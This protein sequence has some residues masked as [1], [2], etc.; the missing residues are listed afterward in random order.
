[1]TEPLKTPDVSIIVAAWRCG[2][3]IRPAI[4]SALAAR[5]VSIEVIVVDDA[6]PDDTFEVL[7][8][9]AAQDPRVRIDRLAA[10]SGPS[11]ARNRAIDLASGE[12]IAVLDA[13]DAMSP[14]RLRHMMECARTNGA[15]IV[16]DDL[17]AVDADGRRSEGRP[18]LKSSFFRQSRPIDLATWVRY[19]TPARGRDSIGYLKPLI[20]RALLNRMGVRY[21]PELR[22][23][24]DYDL[25]A[26]LLAC[27]ARMH[28]TAQAGYFYQR[29]PGSIS[30]RLTPKHT[31]DWIEADIRFNNRFGASLAPDA[32]RAL[33]SRRRGLNDAHLFIC[34]VEAIK[35]GRGRDLPGLFLKSPLSAPF[36]AGVLGRI[37]LGKVIGRRIV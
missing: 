5:D 24:E 11:G 17:I 3:K 7:R 21:D 6:S 15:D 28:F 2:D 9:I 37:A 1:M 13:D 4:H 35:Q 36:S 19:N 18:F 26:R 12:F 27:G 34:S 8:D 29:S 23:G 30:H 20:R 31:R 32:R 10:N 22:N 33:L 16:I 14:E 25:I